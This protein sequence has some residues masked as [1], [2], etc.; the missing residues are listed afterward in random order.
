VDISITSL[1]NCDIINLPSEIRVHILPLI[2]PQ[3]SNYIIGNPHKSLVLNLSSVTFIDSSAIKL[4]VNLHKKMESDKKKLYL[5]KP[6]GDVMKIISEV[7]LDGIF[8]FVHDCEELENALCASDYARYLPF[9]QKLD[10]LQKLNCSCPLCRSENV[11]GYLINGNDYDWKWEGDY[12]Y[13]SAFLK[14]SAVAADV[15]GLRPIVC[16]DCFMCSTTVSDF[17]V[18]D[19][20]DGALRSSLSEEAKLLLSKGGKSRKK[21]IE[22]SDVVIGEDFFSHPRQSFS[23]YMLYQL[24]ESCAHA[25]TAD[26][27]AVSP[28]WIGYYNYLSTKYAPVQKK[29]GH[30]DNCRT[31]LTRV[32]NE[33]QRYNFIYLSKTYFILVVA[34]ISLNKNK[35]AALLF[36][37]FSMMM[38]ALPPNIKSYA[39]G[40]NCPAF[41][42]SQAKTI[43][44]K[45]RPDEIQ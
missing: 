9:T 39:T 21:M 24:A 4:L 27:T 29:D 40:F 37:D 8:S 11:V 34:A 43:L 14:G 6:T 33:R 7:K 15:A 42:F 31:W 1:D 26:K 22:E 2:S 13:P 45:C 36:S 20:T 25:L 41:W 19:P 18:G 44:G 3:L 12:P 5:L 23:I 35:E 28:F 32:I 10:T 16:A 17:N 30:I 38:D